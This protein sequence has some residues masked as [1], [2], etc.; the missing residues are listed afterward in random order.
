MAALGHCDMS[1]LRR[2]GKSEYST[3]IEFDNALRFALKV[4]GSLDLKL[5]PKQLEVVTAVVQQG[6]MF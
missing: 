4:R 2:L 6:G 1:Q 3:D 5:K